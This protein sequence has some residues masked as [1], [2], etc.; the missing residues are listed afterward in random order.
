MQHEPHKAR[1]AFIKSLALCEEM[2]RD[3]PAEARAW[4]RLAQTRMVQVEPL[5]GQDAEFHAVEEYHKAMD[6]FETAARCAPADPRVLENLAWHLTISDDPTIRD[7]ARAVALAR[8]AVELAPDNGI[9][10]NTLGLASYRAG[11]WG[12]AVRVLERGLDLPL[13]RTTLGNDMAMTWFYLA[14][15]YGRLGQDQKA[16]S[17]YDK[18]ARWMD[19]NAPKDEG[20]NHRLRAEATELLRIQNAPLSQSKEV[21]PRKE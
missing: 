2:T 11:S 1:D 14:M 5:A 16:R 19:E 15:A 7:P 13:K 20:L 18:A 9:I 21:R 10:W 8:R 12:E 6:A 3:F 4:L 17:W